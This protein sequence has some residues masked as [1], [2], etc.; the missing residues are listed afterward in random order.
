MSDNYHYRT[1]QFCHICGT[2]LEKYWLEK[3][4]PY[5]LCRTCD[6]RWTQ[7]QWRLEKHQRRIIAEFNATG[8][9]EQEPAPKKADYTGT[10]FEG[11][12]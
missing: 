1:P 3:G 7:K 9:V 8:K 4:N 11:L 6:K 12:S 5:Y 2:E 10:L